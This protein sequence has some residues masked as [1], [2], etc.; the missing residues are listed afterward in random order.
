MN[1]NKLEIE[2][3][4]ALKKELSEAMC[5]KLMNKNLHRA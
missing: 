4:V 2:D 3:H 5:V 1:V